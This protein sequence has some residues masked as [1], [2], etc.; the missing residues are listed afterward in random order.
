MGV[1][2]RM[3]RYRR[4]RGSSVPD[5]WLN[6]KWT[7][8]SCRVRT[9]SWGTM[10]A[11]LSLSKLS[12][13]LL[14]NRDRGDDKEWKSMRNSSRER[15]G[16]SLAPYRFHNSCHRALT[17][18]CGRRNKFIIKTANKLATNHHIILVAEKQWWQQFKCQICC[19]ITD[20]RETYPWCKP[21]AELN[22]C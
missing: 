21:F 20:S 12:F 2:E 3:V 16:I 11:E 19:V 8:S 10:A 22:S 1:G 9:N 4:Q 15:N 14:R 17:R 18:L 13:R 5:S 6:F 7:L